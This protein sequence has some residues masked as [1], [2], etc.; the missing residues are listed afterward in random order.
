MKKHSLE[1]R[2]KMSESAKKR[3]TDS[4]RK[5]RSEKLSTNLDT[6]L[7]RFLYDGGMTQ[8]EIAK[9]LGVT[10]KII[11]RHMLNNG[12]TTRVAAKRNQ[13]KELNHMWKGKE[14]SY[15]AF[16]L[17]VKM[18]KGTAASHG[19]SVCGTTDKSKTY[20]WAN[21]TGLYFDVSDYSPM[22]R[23]C[24]RKYDKKRRGDQNA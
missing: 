17:R 22:C 19:C 2:Q 11:W 6:N 21:L 14:A 20:D 9:Q 3:C 13:R 4:W 7:V 18:E 1:T 5:M 23:S 16:H 12:I 10:Q 15:K 24:H 8:A